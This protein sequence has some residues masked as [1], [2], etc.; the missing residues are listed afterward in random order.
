MKLKKISK[1]G[2]IITLFSAFI[3]VFCLLY[4]VLPPQRFSANEKRVL[5]P[6]PALNSK[7]L[8]NGTFGKDFEGYLSDHFAGRDFFVGLNSYYNLGIGRNGAK[9][10]YA[11]KD[12]YLIEE[13]VAYDKQN[14]D[15]N[16]DAIAKFSEK[17]GIKP[18]L[19]L[20]PSTGY[21]Y[22]D[23]LPPSHLEYLD[24]QII[25]AADSALKGSVN[26]IDLVRPMKQNKDQTQ[27]FYK[28]DHHWTSRGAYVAYTAYCE[29]KGMKPV[30]LDRF[31]AESAGGFYGTTYSRSALW[32]TGPD[33]IE[34]FRDKTDPPFKVEIPEKKLTTD[35]IFFKSHLSEPD[36]YPVFLDGNHGFVKITNPEAKGGKLLVVKDSY[37]HSIAQFLIENYKEVYYVDL[38]YYKQ[39]VSELV[40]K[41]GI[42]NILILY[43]VSNFVSDTNV[44]W[45][46]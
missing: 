22:D 28:T 32:L 46:K 19:M 9:G 4:V 16:I 41:N 42:D 20:I 36:K 3:G 26:A 14:T 17:V 1:D 15:K 8:F 27:L 21:I 38:R 37:A 13:P 2:I 39:S 24:G 31:N 44:V 12:G 10:I 23:K 7:N 40:K 35:S 18:D 43:G 34:M 25:D 29:A 5:Q 6:A 11:G 30:P 45:L 33:T